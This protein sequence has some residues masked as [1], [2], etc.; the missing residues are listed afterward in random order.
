M[1][2]ALTWRFMATDVALDVGTATTRMSVAQKGLVFSEPTVVAVDTRTGKVVAVGESAH[3]A[4]I[5]SPV[6]AVVF[7]PLAKGA[8]VDFDVA[9][10]LFRAVFDRSEFSRLGRI[11]AVMSV[12]TL[13]TSIERRALSQAALQAGAAEVHVMDA[14]IAA[15]I[16]CG[17]PISEPVGSAIISLGAGSTE[18][19]VVSLGG[20]VTS[21]SIRIGANDLDAA[22][23][24]MMRQRYGVVI[25]LEAAAQLRENMGSAL[26]LTNG[27]ST[28]VPARS[29]S[30]GHPVSVEV[31]AKE[32]N[33]AFQDPLSLMMRTISECLGESPPDLA[34]DVLVHGVTVVGGFSKFAD[35]ASMISTSTGLMVNAAPQPEFAVIRGLEMCIADLPK[36]RTYFRS[37]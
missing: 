6:H 19:A 3:R 22:T 13:A 7:R 10:R 24:T 8:T 28:V 15:A 14:P 17:L 32:M 11:R 29:V 36:M 23:T 30:N 31:L 5:E 25:S 12:P 20:I 9:A 18:V 1:P 33:A 26:G 35:M 27:Q 4:V 37:E 2:V 34:Q 21:R 16:G